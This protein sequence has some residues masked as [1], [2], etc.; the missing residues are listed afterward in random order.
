[1]TS[2]Y[3]VA[4]RKNKHAKNKQGCQCK[5][6]ARIVMH[7][8]LSAEAYQNYSALKSAGQVV[9]LAGS[10]PLCSNLEQYSSA[11]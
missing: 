11:V 5:T 10:I 4:T 3:P 6:R 2:I 8:L 9:Q 1:M 7:V